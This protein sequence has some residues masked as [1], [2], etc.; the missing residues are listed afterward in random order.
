[1]TVP[2]DRDIHALLDEYDRGRITRDDLCRRVAEAGTP[3]KQFALVLVARLAAWGAKV[4]AIVSLLSLVLFL[5]SMTAAPELA[6][7]FARLCL[8]AV[9]FSVAVVGAGVLFMWWK[10]VGDES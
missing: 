1:M 10:A 8:S 4:V 5:A 3:V 6:E 7:T 2:T 9:V